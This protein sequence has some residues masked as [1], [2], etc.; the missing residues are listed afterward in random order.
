MPKL[1]VLIPCK[2]EAHNIRE[3]IESVRLIADE[4][5]IA[6]SG[7]T[8][9][10]LDI[11]REIGGCRIIEREYVN[12][13]DFKNWAIPQAA[14]PWVLV[15][16]ADERPG[17]KLIRHICGT[18]SETPKYDGYYIRF[19][20][21]LLGHRLKYSGTQTVSSI[22]LFRKAVSRYSDM[23]VHA[24]VL[25]STEK[26]S[27]LRGRMRHYTCQCLNRFAQTCNRYTTW[28]ALDMYEKGR[29]TTLVGLLVRSPTRFLQFYI[30]RRGFLDRSPG[31]IYCLFIAYY[32]FLKYAKLWELQHSLTAHSLH[33][34]TVDDNRTTDVA[35]IRNKAA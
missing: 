30:L 10:T 23:R 17:P 14:H 21:Y 20:T 1:T 7:S 26:I 32:T 24:D 3:C 25:V 9:E 16:D 31:L 18:L 4:I 29:R 28:S 33:S 2:D 8:D 15:V 19:A 22:R 35:D 6:D 11:I 34:E 12:S 27:Q 5:L 13:A